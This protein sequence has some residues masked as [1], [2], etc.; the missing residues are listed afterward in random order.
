MTPQTVQKY[1]E[2]LNRIEY[3]L[4]HIKRKGVISRGTTLS[5]VS[6]G[7]ENKQKRIREDQTIFFDGLK[8]SRDSVIRALETEAEGIREHIKKNI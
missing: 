8:L 2:K 1:T 5:I 7:I 4:K 3:I 6:K